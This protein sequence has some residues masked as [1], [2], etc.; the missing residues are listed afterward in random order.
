MHQRA[1]ARAAWKAAGLYD[2]PDARL[3]HF[4]QAFDDMP[5]DCWPRVFALARNTCP[6]SLDELAMPLWK[7]GDTLLR[8][9][10]IRH[11]DLLR[12][13][14]HALVARLASALHGERHP[15]ELMAVADRGTAPMLDQMLRR[16]KLP[17]NVR[18]VA[19][20]RRIEIG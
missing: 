7:A 9:N 10:L 2:L 18:A 5:Q 17:A 14:E 8:V 1:A 4:L 19:R 6:E 3:R 12:D 16:R 20:R 11:A 13:D 15:H